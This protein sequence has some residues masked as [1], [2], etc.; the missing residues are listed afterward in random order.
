MTDTAPVD[1]D[2]FGSVATESLPPSIRKLW[3]LVALAEAL[4]L[5]IVAVVIGV[6][7]DDLFVLVAAVGTAIVLGGL[8]VWMAERRYRNWR[9][10]V[11]ERWVE[12]SSGVFIKTTQVVPRNRVQTLTT[13]TGPIDRRLD[14][15]SIIVHTAGTH[16]PN[17]V[18]PH[19][20][21]TTTERLRA[22]LGR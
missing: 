6:A 17:L 21:A 7:V 13:R 4:I 1:S 2:S 11:D 8:R 14:L 20:D 10:G 16:T 9:W 3:L 22:E 18:I 12:R 15:S 5:V 19:L